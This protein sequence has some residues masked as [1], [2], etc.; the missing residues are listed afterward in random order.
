MTTHYPGAHAATDPDRPAQIMA[1][2]GEV[3]T[4][5][6]LHEAATRLARLLSVRRVG[7]GRSHGVLHGEPPP[8]PRGGVGGA[9][10]RA[11][12]HGDQ[13]PADCPTRRP[14]SSTI[15]VP[16]RTSRRPRRPNWPR[17]SWPTRPP[18]SS[19][20]CSTGS[21]TGTTATRK[22]SRPRSADPLDAGIVQGVDMLYSSGTTGQPKGVKPPLRR[23]AARVRRRPSAT[24]C[25][26]LL[27]FEDIDGVPVACPA[28]PRRSAAILAWPLSRS[29][30]P[31]S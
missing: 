29:G 1:A 28:L 26:L 8:V 2:T 27:G 20:S 12:L 7:A 9:L 24:L 10:R 17:R 13:F 16:G 19:G 4:F 31:S 5:G 15:V 6:E 21:S 18:S 22:R 11:L 30:A 23:F 14:T 25:L 3:T